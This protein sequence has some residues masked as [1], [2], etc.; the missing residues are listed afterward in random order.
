[1]NN[2]AINKELKNVL[3]DY[4][5]MYRTSCVRSRNAY[6]MDLP[7]GATTPE[8]NKIYGK[9]KRAE[10]EVECAKLR[11]RAD[12]IL[13]PVIDDLRNRATQ[14]PDADTVN[15]IKLF[16]MR[17]SISRDEVDGMIERYGENPM[18]HKT[19]ADIAKRHDIR[20][21]PDDTEGQLKAAEDF[22]NSLDNILTLDSAEHGHSSDGFFGFIEQEINYHFPTD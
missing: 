11:D 15:A 3:N 9:N 6:I 1:M 5:E 14:A 21:L 4:K 8:Q 13:N 12:S 22:K 10:F 20:V 16:D 2:A 18:A 17:T 7:P 19:I